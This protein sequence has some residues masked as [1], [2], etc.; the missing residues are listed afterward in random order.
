M[1]T[2]NGNGNLL[3]SRALLVT[4]KT[5]A[6]R[7]TKQSKSE[8]AKVNADHHT[9]DAAKVLVRLTDHKAL[10]DIGKLHAEART[11]DR[12]AALCAAFKL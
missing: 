5:G 3:A 2:E 8:S 12:A 11:A 9:A 10:A 7:A 4:L 1:N 6:W